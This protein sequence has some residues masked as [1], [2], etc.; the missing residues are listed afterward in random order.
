MVPYE[1][2][3]KVESDLEG[4]FDY[5]I[6][7]WGI[8]QAQ[9]YRGKLVAHF[10]RIAQKN[11]KVRPFLK[12]WKD[13]Q[14]SKCEHHYVFHLNRGNKPPLVVAVLHENMNLVCRIKERLEE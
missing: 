7:R 2:A 3:P 1:L 4:I 12:H 6:D 8:E 5:T 10:E 13:L 14:I 9:R 11:A